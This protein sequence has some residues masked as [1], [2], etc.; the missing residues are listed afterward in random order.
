MPSSHQTVPGGFF[1]IPKLSTQIC[2]AKEFHDELDGF[3]RE[4]QDCF[5][6]SEPRKS[7]FVYLSGL[8][9]NLEKKSIEPLALETGCGTVRSMQ[10]FVSD[11]PWD[12]ER[13]LRK[14]HT[15]VEEEI[16]SGDGVLILGEYGFP[17]KGRSSVGVARQYCGVFNRIENCQMGV[18]AGYAT[19]AGYALL[20]KR[21][22]IPK[23][24][25]TSPYQ[26]TKN[27][28]KVPDDLTFR[29][30]PQLAA[31]MLDRLVE[32]G[33]IGFKYVM[34]NSSHWDIESLVET[35]E[36]RPETHYFFSIPATAVCKPQQHGPGKTVNHS[37]GHS[38]QEV[39]NPESRRD[40]ITVENLA[41]NISSYFW[42]RWKILEGHKGFVEYEFAR[43]PII[44]YRQGHGF[45]NLWLVIK[46]SLA[47]EPSYQYFVSNAPSG[48]R[49]SD[50]AW[51]TG[52]SWSIDR[53]FREAKSKLGM[54]QYEVRKYAGWHHHMLACM[55]AHFF[56]WHINIKFGRKSS[57]HYGVRAPDTNGQR[58]KSS[59]F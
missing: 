5:L 11:V 32:N 47:E 16:G 19:K 49:L 35:V 55:L 34:A 22:F 30:K 2:S 38:A 53:C 28:C 25:F 37:S 41:K 57:V 15:L 20:D 8:L 43:K 18:F 56:L 48:T 1:D 31:D 33:I 17:K 54:D 44:L 45:R 39:A 46:R 9:S 7:F 26:S 13:M 21:L 12:E 24:W 14:Y 6:R 59:S 40:L 58:K 3:Q 23:S 52:V 51:L 42:Y 10:R 36:R 50:F 29:T 27:K 4:F